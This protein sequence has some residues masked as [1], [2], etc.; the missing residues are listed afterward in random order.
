MV[1]SVGRF[2]YDPGR[3][4]RRGNQ[5]AQF[6]ID[7]A[8]IGTRQIGKHRVQVGRKLD[9]MPLARLLLFFHFGDFTQA[10]GDWSVAGTAI[11]NICLPRLTMVCH[12]LIFVRHGVMLFVA[13][14]VNFQTARRFS[15]NLVDA[16][17]CSGQW[18]TY[19]GV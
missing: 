2:A 5:H 4:E 14:V 13:V 6:R 12:L 8:I 16:V 7:L 9:E 15:R 1:R 10:H 17:A 19:K 18:T 11:E 3:P